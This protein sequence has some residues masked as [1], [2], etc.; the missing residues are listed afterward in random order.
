MSTTTTDTGLV[1]T[2]DAYIASLNETDPTARRALIEQAWAEDAH[3]VDPLLEASGH[4]ALYEMVD[5]IQT[6][7]PGH[8]FHRTTGIDAHHSLVRFGWQLAAPDGTVTV[9]GTDVGIVGPD[10]HLQRIAGFFGELPERE[11]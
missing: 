5:G 11:G 1:S 9:A 6:Q 10:G 3:Y 2:M 8:R 7:F 4:D